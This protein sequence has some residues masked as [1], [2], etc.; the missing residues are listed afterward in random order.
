M[1]ASAAAAMATAVDGG[2]ALLK[3][4]AIGLAIGAVLG[5]I[6]AGL[7]IAWQELRTRTK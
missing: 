3:G 4:S 6:L 5:G 1:I 7:L 2:E